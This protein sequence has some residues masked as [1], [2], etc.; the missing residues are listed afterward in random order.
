MHLPLLLQSVSSI[1]APMSGSV[2]HHAN[3]RVIFD[4][5][6]RDKKCWNNQTPGHAAQWFGY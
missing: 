6:V 4:N 2:F 1:H 5:K 3:I